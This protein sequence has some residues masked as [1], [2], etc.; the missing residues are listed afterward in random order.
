MISDPIYKINI[1]YKCLKKHFLDQV[2]IHTKDITCITKLFKR[3]AL[4]NNLCL[5]TEISIYRCSFVYH[6]CN[7]FFQNAFGNYHRFCSL[8]H[9]FI[10]FLT[11][12][13]IS[14]PYPSKGNFQTLYDIRTSQDRSSFVL[15]P[16][17]F[18]TLRLCIRWKHK[19]KYNNGLQV[20]AGDIGIKYK[21]VAWDV[22]L[23][24]I[25]SIFFSFFSF[26]LRN[27][28]IKRKDNYI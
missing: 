4:Q 15:P 13:F 28:H 1:K 22:D 7:Q 6:Y 26:L 27:S 19:M 23:S 2:C 18:H 21:N 14:K 11:F 12:D 20:F 3:T 25:N 17:L 24:S 10:I 9:S 16:Q 8:A 5:K